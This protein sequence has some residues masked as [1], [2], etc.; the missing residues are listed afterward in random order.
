MKLTMLFFIVGLLNVNAKG[1][2]QEIT[3]SGKGASLEKIFS[4]IKR[5]TRY[6][7]VYEGGLIQKAKPVTVNVVRK[8]LNEFL[9]MVLSGQELTFIIENTTIIIGRKTLTRSDEADTD[10]PVVP[11]PLP[12]FSG[13]IVDDTG[14][15][16]AG[17]SVVNRKSGSSAVTD[18]DGRF[19]ITATTGDA[20][21]VTFVGYEPKE[22]TV[23]STLLN[24]ASF[25]VSLT[26]A[27]N[28]LDEV[29]VGYG[30]M[31]KKDVTGAIATVT[32]KSFNQGFI[33]NPLTQ[34]QGKVAGLVIT[35]PSG[36]PNGNV[37]IRLRGQTS[38]S[39]GQTPLIVVDGIPLDA[40]NLIQN[41]PPGDIA[42]YD[43]LK[44]AS[45][46]AIF[47]SRGA[48]GVIMI[49]TKKGVAGKV[50]VEYN[51]VIGRDKI[52]KKPGILN[53]S[54][55]R[56]RLAAIGNTDTTYDRGGNT[57]WW[58]AITQTG[59]SQSHNLSI[60]GGSNGFR[61]RGSISYLD[62][63]GIVI[64]TGKKEVGVRFNAQQ[65]ALN[66]K[67]DVQVGVLG[68][69]VDR[70]YIDYVFF[71]VANNNPPTYPV[72]RNDGSYFSFFRQDVYNVVAAQTMQTNSGEDALS[73]LYGT[74]DYEL[75]KGLKIGVTGGLNFFEHSTEFY[76]PVFPGVGNLN[77]GRQGSAKT[78]SRRGDGHINYQKS[79][80]EHSVTAT[81][82]YEYNH[83]SSRYFNAQGQQYLLDDLGANALGNG[84]ASS[85]IIGS[86]KDESSLISFLG[87]A[88]YNYA[89]KY[90]LTASVRR[91]GSSKF[92]QNNRWGTFPS[93]S[94]AWRLTQEEFIKNIT[95]L[96]D[97][98]LTAGFGT[99]GNQD[100]ISPYNTLLTLGSGGRYFDAQSGQ[101]PQ[102]YSPVQNANPYLQW[103][104][105]HGKNIG[106][107]FSI[108][109]S[110]I[111]GDI[112]VFNDE[113][114]KL[115]F[116]YSVPTPPF[117]VNSILAN[118]GNMSNKGLEIQLN[119]DIVRSKNVQW[120]LGGQLTL[121]RTKIDQLSGTYTDV[122]LSTDHI[123]AGSDY[124][125][126]N[127]FLTFLQKGYTPYVF[128]LLHS[129][130]FDDDG[131]ELFDDRKGGAVTNQQATDS[132]KRY[133]DPSPKFSY[134]IT[135]TVSYKNWSLNFFL[136]GVAGQKIYNNTRSDYGD[137]SR[138][139]G[140]NVLREAIDNEITGGTAGT[141]RFLENASYLRLDNAT[142]SYTFRNIKAFN[143][144]RLF[145]TGTNLFVITKYSGLDPE[146][147][148]G[149]TNSAYID[150]TYSD[151]FYPRYRSVNVG[152]NVTFN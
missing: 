43:V 119:G 87:R 133:I 15:P 3:F 139:P 107:A 54:E 121:V 128:Y 9:E 105:R 57:D 10:K 122:E 20:L 71:K 38:L 73:Q 28:T 13:K 90:Y 146:V 45:A 74:A 41:I 103:E 81:V 17:A 1:L 109:K 52:V 75:I 114:K 34:V 138:F 49:T 29:V 14:T 118:V 11:V 70:K 143:N 120:N 132:M 112:N 47:G 76:Q 98:K 68:S 101:Y 152:V 129:V 135:S 79:F 37:I 61:Y 151:G 88:T 142:L 25:S 80:G 7:V 94:I 117:F 136:R 148:N 5:Q 126:S 115:L 66:N 32:E 85:N 72:Y 26:R 58:D 48:N 125:N 83:F 150:L 96:D 145:V 19:T 59:I 149:N 31:R 89:S 102:A 36:D 56:A 86:Y 64:N 42:S 82:V 123:G 144:L 12:A 18:A 100:A 137:I 110:R 108:L 24:T 134:G 91:D 30:V 60:S 2:A 99:T 8:P 39:G 131:R 4:E 84:N 63:K 53:A 95:W 111:S 22:I 65:K 127:Y 78:D 62:Q 40:A 141:D 116:T 93:V 33:S 50:Q 106:I 21:I 113:T 23:T 147:K 35:Q 44:D 16:L 97:L 104:E 92:G 46:T 69:H 77:Y 67:L 140:R 124:A 27:N 6:T 51:G 55:Y 130:G